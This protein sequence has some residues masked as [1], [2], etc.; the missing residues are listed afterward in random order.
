MAAANVIYSK[1][2]EH[3]ANSREWV[4]EIMEDYKYFALIFTFFWVCEVTVPWAGKPFFF[5][6]NSHV[7]TQPLVAS[8]QSPPVGPAPNPTLSSRFHLWVQ[9]L[10]AVTVANIVGFASVYDLDVC[11]NTTTHILLQTLLPVSE[12]NFRQHLCANFKL[13]NT[14]FNIFRRSLAAYWACF[15]YLDFQPL[16]H[17]SRLE[18]SKRT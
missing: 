8:L 16:K 9:H 7:T 12:P 4:S 6:T 15:L 11:I 18:K 3:C 1:F 5:Q 2:L 13:S 17:Q 14:N 10:V